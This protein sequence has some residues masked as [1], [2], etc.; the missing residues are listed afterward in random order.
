[1][2]ANFTIYRKGEAVFKLES[3]RQGQVRK[4]TQAT[5]REEIMADDSVKVALRSS[6]RMDFQLR[7]YI[8]YDNRPYLLNRLP[9]AGIDASGYYT[10]NLVF[11]GAMFELGR[12]AFVLPDAFGYEYYGTLAEFARLVVGNMNR[13]NMWVEWSHNGSTRKAKCLY[14]HVYQGETYYGWRDGRGS[15][16][17]TNYIFTRGIPSVGDT[18]YVAPGVVGSGQIT[19]I[20]QWALD[21]PKQQEKPPTYPQPNIHPSYTEMVTVWDNGTAENHLLLIREIED[22]ESY[23]VEEDTYEYGLNCVLVSG[24]ETFEGQPPPQPAYPSRLGDSC[25]MQEKVTF[26]LHYTQWHEDL[27]FGGGRVVEDEWYETRSVFRTWTYRAVLQPGSTW[28][29]DPIMPPSGPDTTDDYPTEE[30]LLAYDAHSCLAVMQDLAAQEEWKDWEWRIVDVEHGYVNGEMLVCGTIMLRRREAVANSG[31]AHVLG[32]GRSGG[33]SSIK[34]KYADGAN[35]PSRVYFYGGTQNLPEYY[36]NSR[37]CLPKKSKEESY[38]DFAEL[39]STDFPLGIA[40]TTCEEV[41]LIDG[42]YPASK[43]FTI[44]TYA[45]GWRIAIATSG[46]KHYLR[47]GIPMA[48]FFDITAKWSDY[49]WPDR[50]ISPSNAQDVA[51]YPDFC[52]WLVWKQLEDIYEIGVGWPNRQQYITYYA[53]K[54]VSKYLASG[55]KPM[56]TFQTGA[57]AGYSLSVHSFGIL[58]SSFVADLN[59]VK[60]PNEEIDG[61][62]FT[63]NSEVCCTYGDKFIVENID[64]P[65]AYTYYNGGDQYESGSLAHHDFSAEYALWKAALGYMAEVAEKVNYEI[66]V[67]RSR[68]IRHNDEFRCYDVVQFSDTLA[69]GTPTVKRRITAVELDLVD[70][71]TYKL[72]IGNGG[73]VR[74]LAALGQIIQGHSNTD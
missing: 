8:V 54:G 36:R 25:T 12:V 23:L 39:E 55:Q 52:E 13:V 68:V 42:I 2:S 29:I 69:N 74:P 24:S 18:W 37:L 27:Q 58:G 7:D 43:P 46:T 51:D 66:E 21:F 38:I 40:N 62:S 20:H 70:G 30:V 45:D 33:I 10:Y 35:V 16:S 61:D 34:R 53:S 47:L 48:V 60:E 22:A 11:E 9:E 28:Q 63:P 50:N 6:V 65:V 56:I 26:K 3:R 41:R 44:G 31:V 64:M 71:Y 49:T 19:A 32:F 1:M 15:T 72:T 73:I 14:T 59:V 17:G 67:A 4:V 5:F 57:L